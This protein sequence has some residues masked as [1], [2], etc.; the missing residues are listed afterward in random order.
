MRIGIGVG[1]D[2][3]VLCLIYLLRISFGSAQG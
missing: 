3:D 1:F 2:A